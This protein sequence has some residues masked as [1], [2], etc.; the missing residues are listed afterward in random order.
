VSGEEDK[1]IRKSREEDEPNHSPQTESMIK[2]W[3]KKPLAKTDTN[4]EC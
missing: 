4:H 3:R 1:D 2:Q